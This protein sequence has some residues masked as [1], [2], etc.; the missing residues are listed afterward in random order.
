MNLVSRRKDKRMKKKTQTTV[1]DSSQTK[2]CSINVC[3]GYGWQ[4]FNGDDS[5]QSG[6]DVLYDTFWK[7][8][9]DMFKPTCD[10]VGKRHGIKV[11]LKRLRASHG[12]FVW[13]TIARNIDNANVLIFDVAAAPSKQIPAKGEVEFSKVLK[14]LNAN[15][16]LEIGYALGKDKRVMLMCPQHLFKM[17]PSDLNGFLWTLYKGNFKD[18]KIV[19][20]FVDSYG[21]VNAFRGMLQD[22]L[23]EGNVIAADD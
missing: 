17:I 3:V 7:S 1:D 12:R 8:L 4:K 23:C 14:M 21:A 19:R 10:G 16:L 18:G 2:G 22:I 9:K 11:N 5:R 15:V 6:A 13:P 20:N